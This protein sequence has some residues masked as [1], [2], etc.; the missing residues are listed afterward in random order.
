MIP[1]LKGI[2]L[3]DGITFNMV[4]EIQ[5]DFYYYSVPTGWLTLLR[6]TKT[7]G[8]SGSSGDRA[9]SFMMQKNQKKLLIYYELGGKYNQLFRTDDLELNTKMAVNVKQY[10]TGGQYKFEIWIDG[11]KKL[12][13]DNSAPESHEGIRV[14]SG[15]PHNDPVDGRVE[16]LRV[17]PGK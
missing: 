13:K 14:Q 8:S 10:E 9:P 2:T 17:W 4:Y 5:F 3:R 1:L 11:A 6:F 12:E 16:N 7:D 15:G